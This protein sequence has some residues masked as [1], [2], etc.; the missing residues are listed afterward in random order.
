[1]SLDLTKPLALNDGTP[2][3]L[4]HQSS[5]KLRIRVP[6]DHPLCDSEYGPIRD[7]A[8]DGTR[9]G[10]GAAPPRN[11]HLVNV[12]PDLLTE[13]DW[14]RLIYENSHP[15]ILKEIKRRNLI[16]PDPDPVTALA[17]RLADY[18]DYPDRVADIER[19]LRE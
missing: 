18:F 8:L 9:D 3:E 11:Y 10:I 19:M 1:M 16:K 17:K 12:E 2:V 14:E 13:A 7:F 15:D 5:F 6:H 4:V